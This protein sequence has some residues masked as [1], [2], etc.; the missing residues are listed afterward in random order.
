MASLYACRRAS[1]DVPCADYLTDSLA[2]QFGHAVVKRSAWAAN[3]CDHH[4]TSRNWHKGFAWS[5]SLASNGRCSWRRPS[6]CRPPY[7]PASSSQTYTT[8]T[9]SSVGDLAC[10]LGGV[11][12]D[13]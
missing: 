9:T 2:S 1:S 6:R 10:D 3:R 12:L 13:D 4:V 7:T 5:L 8:S 11:P